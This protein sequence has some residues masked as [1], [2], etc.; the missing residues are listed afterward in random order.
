MVDSRGTLLQVEQF[1]VLPCATSP[2][3]NVCVLSAPKC[4]ECMYISYVF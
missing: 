1:H 2:F 4:R 3:S